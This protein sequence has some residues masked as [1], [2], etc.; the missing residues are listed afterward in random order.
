MMNK[1][2]EPNPDTNPQDKPP[3][4]NSWRNM[5]IFVFGQLIVLIVFLYL[6]TKYFS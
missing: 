1:P 2:A 4:F 3:I 5:Y 6:F